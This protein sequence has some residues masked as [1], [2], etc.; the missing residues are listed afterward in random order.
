MTDIQ[1]LD[2]KSF[3]DQ[4]EK[5]DLLRILT[6]GSVDDGKSTLIGRLLF[7]SKKLYDDQLSALERDSKRM[8]HAGEEIDYALLLDGL[9]AEREQGITI[10]VAYRYFSTNKRKFIIADTPG[11]EQ[12]TRNMVTGASTANLA[13]LLVDARTGI[14]T[15][16][17]RHTYITS[18]LGIKHIVV[19]INKMDLVDFD[20]RIYDTIC[21]D[22]KNFITDMNIPDISFIPISAL[23][24]DNVVDKSDHMP[25]Y[26]GK[27]MLEFLETVHVSSDRNFEDLRFP[28][29]FVNRPDI[30]FRGFATTIASGIIKKGDV[31]K[32]LPSGQT[33]TVT[34]I[35]GSSGEQEIAF[36]PQA[37]TIT[38]ADEIDI[39][40]G[41]MI[42][43][44]DNMPRVERHF[45]A[46]MVWMDEK[47]MNPS[48]QFYIKHTTNITK[49]RFDEV[50]YKVDVNTME[51]SEVD[52][53]K[54][55]EIGRV[56]LTTVK[57]LFFDPYNKNRQ[58][59][60]FVLIDPVSNNTCAVGMIIDK[61]QDKDLTSRIIEKDREKI[62][63][64]EALISQKERETRLNQKGA[65]IWITGLHGSGK[66]NLAYSLERKLFDEGATVV[67]MDGSTVRSGLSKELDYSP[68]DRAEHLRRVAHVCNILNEQGIITICSFISPIE[69]IRKQIAEI[70]GKDRFHL[71]YMNADLD[72]CKSHKP[73]FYAKV[74]AGNLIHVP[75]IDETFEKPLIADLELDP[76]NE[77]SNVEKIIQLINSKSIF[78]IG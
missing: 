31:I 69:E 16:T 76:H 78:P 2:I 48:N 12:Y 22:Y 46:M 66:N 44:P 9:K 30:N 28:V 51:K 34:S 25:W 27:C 67:L 1:T 59:G 50:K 70:I 18:L 68:A 65:T 58:T 42:V 60:S 55:N 26:H 15:Q 45:E 61:L 35:L 73:E 64:G 5:K 17:K 37:V 47:P 23:K 3:L 53:F 56:V 36:P 49:V 8:G 21:E 52:F 72:F 43:H 7:D 11:H 57:P 63:R 19:A 33:S 75:G 20:Q 62:I 38:L 13:I 71:I 39:S 40:R 74:E 54:L 6:A 24:G 77:K 14:I 10:D 41:E 32:A 29:Q 4:D